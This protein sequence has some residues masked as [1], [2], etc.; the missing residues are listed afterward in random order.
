MA[1]SLEVTAVSEPAAS[2]LL[3]SWNSAQHTFQ[4]C[5][6]AGTIHDMLLQL[7]KQHCTEHI[8]S[9][10]G[11]MVLHTGANSGSQE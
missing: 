3:L 2:A 4:L 5:F 10:S 8:D 1:S 6:A 9:T 11:V 7:C